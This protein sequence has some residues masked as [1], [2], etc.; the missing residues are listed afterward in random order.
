MDFIKSI[1]I[2][3]FF[4]SYI[5]QVATSIAFVHFSNTEESFFFCPKN[6]EKQ[7]QSQAYFVVD[8]VHQNFF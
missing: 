4:E 7:L 6:V 2:S 8:Y 5:F 1:S 3:F